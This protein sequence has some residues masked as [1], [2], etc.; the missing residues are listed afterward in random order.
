VV[1]A[2]AAGGEVWTVHTRLNRVSLAVEDSRVYWRH[3]RPGTPATALAD[4]AFEERWFGNRSFHRVRILLRT[5]AQRFDAYPDALAV[6]HRWQPSDPGT[7]RLLCHWHTQLTDPLYRRYTGELL[8]E[9]WGRRQPGSRQPAVDRD[10]TARWL[11]RQTGPRWSPATALRI[12]NGLLAAAT[13]AGLCAEGSGR[14]PLLPVAVP[15]EALTYLLYLLRPRA[16]EG[17]LLD[18]P[19]LRSV[20]LTGAALEQALRHLD[21][22]DYRRHGDLHDLGWRFDDLAVWA[23][24]RGTP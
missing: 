10:V 5:F 23:E 15:G 21:A 20:G 13:E 22:L 16:I 18:N 8:P 1:E 11:D 19:Y 9:R 12:A 6:L 2:T 3:A 24:S 4:A 14:R 17:T 7:R